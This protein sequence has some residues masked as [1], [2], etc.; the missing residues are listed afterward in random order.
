GRRIAILG[1]MLELG[2]DAAQIHRSLAPDAAAL[3]D[4][5]IHLHGEHTARL[6]ADPT[7]PVRHW[8]D[9]DAVVTEICATVRAGDVVLVKASNGTG[10]GV[11]VEALRS[12]AVPSPDSDVRLGTDQTS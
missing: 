11:V 4:A 2:A 8:E 3:T 9:R 6:A 12:L 5:Q 10:L 1:D 7:G